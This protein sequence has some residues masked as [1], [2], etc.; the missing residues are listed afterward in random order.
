MKIKLWGVRG[1]L[2]T[3]ILPAKSEQKIKNL[4][5]KFVGFQKENSS[6]D[7]DEFVNSLPK[8]KVSGFGGNTACVQVS[9]EKQNLII[10]G[11]SGIRRLG[12][13]LACGPCGAGQGEVHILMTHFHWDHLIGLPFFIPIF[14]PGNKIHIY[15]VQDDAEESFKTLF[16][17]PNFPVPYE[18]LGAD[19]IYH[20]LEPRKMVEFEDLKVTP[21]ELDHPDPCWGYKIEH[22][23][24][25]F[26]YC[27]DSEG[28]RVSRQDLGLDLPLYQNVDLMVFDAQY[29]FLEAAERVDWGHSSAPIGLD[30]AMREGVKETL[31][32]HHDPAAS[33][34]H[35]AEV[36]EQTRSYYE[37]QLKSAAKQNKE[38]FE[39]D[40]HFAQEGEEYDL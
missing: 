33:D 10:D 38:V 21:Y 1:S 9:S 36:E 5:H 32:V 18:Y 3:P 27:V 39:V 37:A 12:E 29:S 35:I 4:L 30:I 31:F 28:T 34:E 8:Y 20:Q 17:K 22:N 25:T 2:P 13:I 6:S 16:K 7:V 14:I 23:G 40:W 15:S 24:K 19:I 26:S 11:G